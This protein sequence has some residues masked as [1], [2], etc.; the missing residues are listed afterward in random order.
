VRVGEKLFISFLG[1]SLPLFGV[2]IGLSQA[3]ERAGIP[4]ILLVGVMIMTTFMG[5]DLTT[6]IALGFVM[7][8]QISVG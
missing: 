6:I 4:G 3:S 2:H 5:Y 7:V 8:W 1:F